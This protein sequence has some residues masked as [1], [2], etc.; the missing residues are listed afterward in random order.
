LLCSGKKVAES[1]MGVVVARLLG[2][3]GCRCRRATLSAPGI[4]ELQRATD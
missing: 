1:L 4:S 2:V 3:E